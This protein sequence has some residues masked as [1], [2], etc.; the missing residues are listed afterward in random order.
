[1]YNDCRQNADCLSSHLMVPS[2][3]VKRVE[4]TRAKTKCEGIAVNLWNHQCAALK[5]DRVFGLKFLLFLPSGTSNAKC[6]VSCLVLNVLWFK[7]RSKVSHSVHYESSL[8]PTILPPTRRVQRSGPVR[9]G[10]SPGSVFLPSFTRSLV[11]LLDFTVPLL[12]SRGHE[13]CCC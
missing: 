2:N 8:F 13:G 4:I 11:H 10:S 7:T 1:M 12:A 9:S 6:R 5:S 3:K